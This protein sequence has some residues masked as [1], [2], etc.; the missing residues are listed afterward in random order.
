MV[1]TITEYEHVPTCGFEGGEHIAGDGCVSTT[2]ELTRD[3]EA[4][5]YAGLGWEL[6]V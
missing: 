1:T 3:Q 6:P 5:L 4:R 2:R